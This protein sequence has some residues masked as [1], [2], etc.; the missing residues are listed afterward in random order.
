MTRYLLDT[1]H[2]SDLM[3]PASQ[4]RNR[5]FQETRNRNRVG[6]CVPVLCEWHAG[7][8]HSRFRERRRRALKPLLKKYIRIWPLDVTVARFYGEV[9]SQLRS[10]GR[11]LSQVD[12]MLAA[13]ARQMNLTLVT[14]DRDFEALPDLD[15]ENQLED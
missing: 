11:S 14:A 9:F 6:I 2:F 13:L 7:I 5:V 1:N 8:E 4:I 10:S 3:E 15:V 12:M